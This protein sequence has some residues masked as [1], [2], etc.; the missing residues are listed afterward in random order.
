MRF[1][2]LGI[3]TCLLACAGSLAGQNTEEPPASQPKDQ[4]F[5][6]YITAV[7]DTQITVSRTVLGKQSSTRTFQITPETRIEGKPKVK[8]KV[9]VQFVAEEEG[10]RAVHIIVRETNSQPPPPKKG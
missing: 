2:I 1:I 3:L 9:T 5:A 7:S 10:D 6:G 4:F 8:A